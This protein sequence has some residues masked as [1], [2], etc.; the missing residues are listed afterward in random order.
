MPTQ[1]KA[2]IS[3]PKDLADN[4][5][6]SL[7]SAIAHLQVARE[8]LDQQSIELQHLSRPMQSRIRDRITELLGEITNIDDQC[9]E[10]LFDI[11]ATTVEGL[12]LRKSLLL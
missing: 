1:N 3:L 6:T 12:P 2:G 10:M 7:M 5:P 9:C 11:F 8:M 4:F